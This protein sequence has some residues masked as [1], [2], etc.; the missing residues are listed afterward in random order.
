MKIVAVYE[1]QCDVRA[2]PQNRLE[3]V[4]R[5]LRC[6]MVSRVGATRQ[7]DFSRRQMDPGNS[8]NRKPLE[9]RLHAPTGIGMSRGDFEAVVRVL[10]EDIPEI[11]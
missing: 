9:F 4:A 7:K 2:R 10:E 3:A 11:R 6:P 8:R 1:G 5:L